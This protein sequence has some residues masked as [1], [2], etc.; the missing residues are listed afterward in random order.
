MDAGLVT[1]IIKIRR[2]CRLISP[3]LLLRLTVSAFPWVRADLVG[4]GCRPS[5]PRSSDYFPPPHGLCY[6]LGQRFERMTKEPTEPTPAKATSKYPHWKQAEAYLRK[7]LGRGR[8]W[9]IKTKL[10]AECR[11]SASL[12]VIV[13]RLAP[14]IYEVKACPPGALMVASPEEG[15]VIEEFRGWIFVND[16]R[17]RKSVLITSTQKVGLELYRL[18]KSAI[19]HEG[20]LARAAFYY[21]R[22]LASR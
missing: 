8:G 1:K 3:C 12:D 5:L 15:A 22:L 13:R 18:V 2:L 21:R 17:S 6:A 20:T 7:F 4:K 16:P 14:H 11:Y 9:R 10:H 19:R